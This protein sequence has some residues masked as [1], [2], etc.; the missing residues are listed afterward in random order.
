MNKFMTVMSDPVRAKHVQV[1]KLKL[2]LNLNKKQKHRRFSVY[3]KAGRLTESTGAP[4]SPRL[5]ML[6]MEGPCL[7]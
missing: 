4:L 1:F 5:D 2:K 3:P 7:M 6:F